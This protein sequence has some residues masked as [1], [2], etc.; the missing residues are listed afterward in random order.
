[1]HREPIVP[2]SFSPVGERRSE[3]P[4]EYEERLV[5]ASK[6]TREE[7]RLLGINDIDSLIDHQET[8]VAFVDSDMSEK[9]LREGIRALEQKWHK[10]DVL[11]NSDHEDTEPRSIR[12]LIEEL[13]ELD[14]L[15][16]M[17]TRCWRG[18]LYDIGDILRR[19]PSVDRGLEMVAKQYGYPEAF[20]ALPLE[21]QEGLSKEYPQI[22]TL[23]ARSR[24]QAIPRLQEIHDR[25]FDKM[26]QETQRRPDKV[27]DFLRSVHQT[28]SKFNT[29]FTD[30]LLGIDIHDI[31][32][33]LDIN[34]LR[35]KHDREELWLGGG[36]NW[37]PYESIR[38]LFHELPLSDSDVLYD[39]GSGYGRVPLY[40]SVINEKTQ[41]KGI[42][43]VPER[44]RE[45]AACAERLGL[46]NISFTEANVLDQDF[47]DGTVFFLF[48][49]FSR[50]TMRRVFDKLAGLARTKKIRVCAMGGLPFGV[51]WLEEVPSE[52]R[53]RDI[54]I[55]ES[56]Y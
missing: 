6:R 39:L 38:G 4:S 13:C 56:T 8:Y 49:P 54:R 9:D 12:M 2:S 14:E 36:F 32:S 42:E 16:K 33:H 24:I 11:V 35:K 26:K 44:V 37:T 34:G 23:I 25:L 1:M 53:R 22:R 50:E 20:L 19:G 7:A 47:S 41:F 3:Q 45:S 17:I 15:L 31:E 21:E 30:M 28:D 18:V 27:L 43:L 51:S 48:N 52:N 55:F 10:I 29:K 5:K 40:G 46:Q